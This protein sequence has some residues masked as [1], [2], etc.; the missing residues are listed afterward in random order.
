MQQTSRLRTQVAKRAMVTGGAQIY[1]TVI[2]F[3]ASIMLARLLTPEDYGLVAIASSCMA[4]VPV[5]QDLSL[6][7]ATVQRQAISLRQIDALFW[8][9]AGSGLVFAIMLM[10][11]APG[12]AWL[13]ENEQL[14]SL[15]AAFAATI[16]VNGFQSQQIA[17][18]NRQLRF[19]VLAAIDIFAATAGVTA[20]MTIA[21]LTSS[22]WALV[23]PY[24]VSTIISVA[25]V[26]IFSAYRPGLP[27]F[28]GEFREIFRFSSSVSGYHLANYFARW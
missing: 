25:C 7:Q 9:S 4:L 17:L 19:A 6:N 10:L 18:M 16:A 23:A 27:S 28:E 11:L 12:V 22:Y 26:W 2:S 24:I 1:R 21:W 20:A 13:F 14:T 8:I 15:I 5:I 3:V